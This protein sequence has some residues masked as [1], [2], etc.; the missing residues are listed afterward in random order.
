MIQKLF[1]TSKDGEAKD[2]L[3]QVFERTGAKIYIPPTIDPNTG[4]RLVEITGEKKQI[5]L[6]LQEI[7]SFLSEVAYQGKGLMMNP[8]Y[9]AEMI[10]WQKYSNFAY[11]GEIPGT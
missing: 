11:P 3:R 1:E 7:A 2:V 8:L 4:N 5:A 9:Y 6:A 10:G